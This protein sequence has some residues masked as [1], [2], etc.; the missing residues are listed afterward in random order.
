MRSDKYSKKVFR[1]Y[2]EYSDKESEKKVRTES[3]VH[4]TSQEASSG[5]TLGYGMFLIFFDFIQIPLADKF[6]LVK[7]EWVMMANHASIAV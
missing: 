3:R 1:Y 4:T 6:I 2:V 5:N 7:I